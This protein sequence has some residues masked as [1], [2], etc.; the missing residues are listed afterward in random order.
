MKQRILVTAG[1]PYANGS[2]HL[3]HL[4][5]YCQADF[6]VRA[7]KRLGEN[8][9]YICADDTHGTPIE[10][11]AARQGVKPTE[12]IERYH[13]EHKRDFAQFDVA[14]DYFGSTNNDTNRE[15]VERVYH[16]LRQK[17]ALEDRSLDGNWCEKDERFLPDRFIK[18]ECPNCNAADQYG[19]VCEVCGKT[20]SPTDL[21]NARCVLCGGT[22]VIR[23]SDHV[24]FKLSA[25]PNVE[26]LRN[27]IESGALLSDT[28]NYVKSWLD[29]G[30]RDW[31]ISRDGPY[32]GFAIPDRPGKFFYVW[33][34]APLGYVS[35]SVE[36]GQQ[37]KIDFTE[38]WQ[39]PDKTRIEHFIG[40][41]IV[42]FHTLFWPAVLKAVGYTLPS[43]IHVNGMLTVEG[44]KMSKTR[45]TFINAATFAEHIEPQAL[46][47]YYACRSGADSSD[48]DLSFEDFVLRVNSELVNKHAN[49]FS[50]MSQFLSQKL[51][52][53]LGDLPFLAQEAQAAPLLTTNEINSMVEQ[54][55]RVVA[56]C[57]RVEEL[58]RKR[59]FGQVVRELAG[60]A[61]IGNEFMQS[62]KPWEQLKTDPEKARETLTFA[63]NV[64]YALAMYLWPI[65]PKFSE[66]GARVLGTT[67]D[68]IDA[69]R[70]FAER[71]RKLGTFERLFERIERKQIDAIVDASKQSMPDTNASKKTNSAETTA[72][73]IQLGE[74]IE[75]DQFSKVDLRVGL[76][77]NAESVPKSQKLIRL[78]VDLGEGSS[79]QIIAGIAQ[80]YSPNV[81]VGTRIVVVANLKPAKLMGLES[82]GMVLA[83]GETTNMS[84]LRIEKELAPGTKVK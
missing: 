28:A 66:A 34:D 14:F 59:E 33:L 60:V 67:I 17:E 18:G 42:Y 3:G 36:W 41:D 12:L 1:L 4:V 38:L 73:V 65:V 39:A 5:G 27:W 81:L 49:L 80:S 13:K 48:L 78:E 26:F 23:K 82:R 25:A 75:Y 43:A 40:K 22:P 55:R 64:C 44:E 74:L 8:A 62:A 19:D 72:G 52:N 30:L 68:S 15:I 77:V 32:F 54:A 11:N 24:F 61:D 69:T 9:I 51:D 79:R 45:G 16:E 37:N 31:C 53:C 56:A 50:R 6:Y 71:K 7:H 57:R 58:Y 21:K 70:L 35:A 29:S 10:L 2:I 47:Y 84:L 63:A 20:Y 76:I 83:A 46:R